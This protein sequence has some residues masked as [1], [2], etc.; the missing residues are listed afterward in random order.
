MKYFKIFERKY[1][2]G[3]SFVRGSHRLT[4]SRPPALQPLSQYLQTQFQCRQD[5]HLIKSSRTI[6]ISFLFLSCYELVISVH[7]PGGICPCLRNHVSCMP[8][9]QPESER[10]K[11][12]LSLRPNSSDVSI[13]H[14]IKFFSKNSSD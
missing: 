9:S 10:S 1:L 4:N 2:P 12:F 8:V 13:A 14:L 7:W 5:H 6:K 3:Q 11:L